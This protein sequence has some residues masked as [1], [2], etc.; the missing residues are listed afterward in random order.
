MLGN[1]LW[2][3]SVVRVGAGIAALRWAWRVISRK[4]AVQKAL[5]L[6]SVSTCLAPIRHRKAKRARPDQNNSP[7]GSP[8]YAGRRLAAAP[9]SRGSCCRAR[10]V[11]ARGPPDHFFGSRAMGR[12]KKC[13]KGVACKHAVPNIGF[14]HTMGPQPEVR[15]YAHFFLYRYVKYR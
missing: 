9:S 14:G 6:S 4:R 10:V 2:A 7:G 5:G 13:K 3:R 11:R 1:T 12:Q 15:V 8:G